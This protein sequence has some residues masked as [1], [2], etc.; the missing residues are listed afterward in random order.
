VIVR[1]FG[2]PVE[3]D[4][5]QGAVVTVGTFDGLHRGHQHLL[6]QM[7]KCA[8]DNSCATIVIT[9]EPHPQIVLKKPGKPPIQLLTTL[10]ERLARFEQEGIDGVVV[11]PFSTEFAAMNP[12][13]FVQRVVEQY[14]V[15]HFFIGHDHMFGNNRAGNEEILLELGKTLSFD[16][17]PVSAFQWGD[18]T[19]SSTK[20]RAALQE[21]QVELAAELIGQ[22]YTLVG[23]VQEGNKQGATLGFPTTNIVSDNQHK[24]LPKRGVYAVSTVI[25]GTVVGGMANIGVRPTMTNDINETLEVHWLSIDKN[26]YNATLNVAFISRIRDEQKFCSVEQLIQQLHNDKQTTQLLLQERRIL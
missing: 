26:L 8:N 21:G 17:H 1:P 10:Q 16:V 12:A 3:V 9:F 2:T 15:H 20:I 7:K 23:T 22:P 5:R 6:R 11:I 18:A 25:D 13:A 24:L 14:F 4:G 19:I